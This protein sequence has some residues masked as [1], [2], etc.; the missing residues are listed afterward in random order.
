[1]RCK[2]NALL[3]INHCAAQKDYVDW[4]FS[5]LRDLVRTPPR[6]RTGNGSR[7]AY[8]FTTLSLPELTPY[9]RDFYASGR[10]VIPSITL[11]PLTLA[12][13]FMDDGCKSYGA[14]YFNTQQF[15]YQ[16]Q[17]LMLSMMHQQL[18][19]DGTLN[20]DKHYF[21]IRVAV[22]SVAR[23][24]ELIAPFLLPTMRYKLPS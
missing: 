5:I 9:Y 24:R 10:K 20:R 4:K 12:V 16:S 21:R 15:D 23:L 7:E 6:L 2:K 3:E 18:G 22:K 11:T 19:I 17:K 14:V 13:W 8:R 1:M